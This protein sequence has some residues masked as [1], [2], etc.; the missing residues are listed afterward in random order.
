MNNLQTEL[1]DI[2]FRLRNTP[3]DGNE[4]KRMALHQRRVQIITENPDITDNTIFNLERRRRPT[5]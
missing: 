1:I 5:K 3:V 4:M 2:T